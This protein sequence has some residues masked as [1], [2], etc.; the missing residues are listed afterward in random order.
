MLLATAGLAPVHVVAALPSS[1]MNIQAPP[2]LTPEADDATASTGSAGDPGASWRLLLDAGIN[3]WGGER[4]LACMLACGS[5]C[6]VTSLLLVCV[7]TT[8]ASVSP[9]S[10]SRD[11]D[12]CLHVAPACLLWCHCRP[13]GLSPV[14][15]D[16]VN[17]ERPWPHLQQL[18]AATA[19]TGKALL[20]RLPLYPAY[21]QHQQLLPAKAPPGA[22]PA[23][24]WLDASGRDSPMAAAL[25]LADAEGLGRG[26][27]WYAGAAEQ[28]GAQQTAAAPAAAAQEGPGPGGVRSRG[29]QELRSSMP[30]PRRR[31]AGSWR[32]AVGGDGLL[33]GCARPQQ[34]APDVQQLLSGVLE[35]RLELS[36][37]DMELLFSGKHTCTLT[38]PCRQCAGAYTCT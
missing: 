15:R 22:Q 19:A 29:R 25:R 1:Q 34:V 26:S 5:R 12:W 32:I 10:V 18:A 4:L 23:R 38:A 8:P 16:F 13:A 7:V 2:N 14:T 30:A 21:L 24:A 3:D 35:G 17:P 33:E 9:V 6:S 36:E 20:P 11:K 27:T 37:A 31:A 28:E